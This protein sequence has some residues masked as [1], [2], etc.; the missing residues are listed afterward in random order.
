MRMHLAE[1]R[2]PT[3]QERI[4]RFP[5][6]RFDA[7]GWGAMKNKIPLRPDAA[8]E[9]EVRQLMKDRGFDVEL[10]GTP[11]GTETWKLMRDDQGL[12]FD[13]AFAFVTERY[14]KEGDTRPLMDL[15][16]RGREPS[17]STCKLLAVMMLPE[18][19]AN[20]SDA[21][22]KYEI[23]F[24]PRREARRPRLDEQDAVTRACKYMMAGVAT[25]AKGN[26]PGLHFWKCLIA[27]LDAEHSR[28]APKRC[29]K[30]RKSIFPLKGKLVRIDGTKGR[31]ADPVLAMRNKGL[32]WL[33]Q[34]R[35]DRGDGYKAAIQGTHEEI[36]KLANDERWAGGTV[37]VTTVRNAYDATKANGGK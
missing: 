11:W 29:R 21:G 35:I 16:F 8:R 4:A 32:A 37:S 14:L 25:M 23:G 22:I 5:P 6:T 1:V 28:N 26:R 27:S 30:A 9:A 19:R 13:H 15:L 34:Q 33:V 20:C 2:M 7:C 31:G 24:R 10:A 36:N 12:D 3:I 18:I 17:E